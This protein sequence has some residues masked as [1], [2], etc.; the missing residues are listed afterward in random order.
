MQVLGDALALAEPEGFIRTFVD[1]GEPMAEMLGRM[2]A[3]GGAVEYNR[4]MKEYIFKILA[5]FENQS[6]VHSF[7]SAQDKPSSE[8]YTSPIL[9]PSSLTPQPLVE[10]LSQ[11]ELEVLQ[12]IAQGL[13]NQEIAVRLYLSLNT[14]KVHTRNINSKLGVSSRTKAVASARALG[15]LARK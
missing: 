7:G 1:E 5:A 2:R 12:L 13:T 15:I 9:H 11:R 8:L 14:V 4:R 10:P 6:D 3:E